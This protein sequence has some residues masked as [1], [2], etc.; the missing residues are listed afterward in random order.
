MKK[1]LLIAT[2]VSLLFASC[3]NDDVI[4][5]GTDNGNTSE[6]GFRTL[7]DKDTRASITTTDNITSFTVTAWWDKINAKPPVPVYG[8]TAA[9]GAYLFN[10]YNIARG[11]DDGNKWDYNPKAYWP[12]AGKGTVDFFAYSP[13]SSVNITDKKGIADF[14]GASTPIEY[15]VPAISEDGKQQEDFLVAKTL[16]LSSG[17][18]TLDFK[19]ALS[20]VKFFARKGNP[21]VT[22]TIGKVEL[23]NLAST[24]NFNYTTIDDDTESVKWTGH[25]AKNTSYTA[26]MGDSPIMLSYDADPTKYSS[27][28]GDVNAI[29]VMPQETELSITGT[30][31]PASNKFAIAISYKAYIDDYYYA[32]KPNEWKTKYFAVPAS[33]TSGSIT[34][35]FGKQYNFNLTFGDEVGDAVTFEVA[36]SDWT[37]TTPEYVPELSDYTDLVTGFLKTGVTFTSSTTFPPISGKITKSDLLSVTE[38]MVKNSANPMDFTGIEYFENLETLDLDGVKDGVGLDASKNAKLKEARFYG[39]SN[40]GTV[41]LSNTALTTIKFGTP[42]FENLNLSNT[43]LTSFGSDKK[44]ALTAATVTGTLDLSGCGLTKIDA[45][46]STIPAELNLSNNKIAGTYDLSSASTV[47]RTSLNLSNNKIT[48]LKVGNIVYTNINISNNPTLT[49]L[50]LDKIKVTG[51]L[52]ASGNTALTEIQLGTANETN[53]YPIGVLDISDSKNLGQDKLNIR[54]G[55]GIGTLILWNS[56]TQSDYEYFKNIHT[57]NTSDG[58]PDA[59][60]TTVK[61]KDGSLIS[62]PP[63]P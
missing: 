53:G 19:H 3:S 36:T 54:S 63:T 61:R 48:E 18:V 26:D 4:E 57:G 13:A 39:S 58:Y 47:T 50:T 40:L 59:Y 32:G 38:I 20:R 27:I 41:D 1:I 49:K 22:Y 56:C 33:T 16:G 7:I 14:K 9:E 55:Y 43:K 44:I 8:G 37:D 2:T 51:E 24:A 29:M 21:D 11:E 5:A 30:T 17:K 42:T 52:N 23:V 28:L 15:T 62:T 45:M 25:S 46:P 10:A 31:A 12:A 35:E 34:F 60:I 6:I